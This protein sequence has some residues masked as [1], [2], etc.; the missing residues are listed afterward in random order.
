M[1]HD[2]IDLYTRAKG[3]LDTIDIEAYVT[4]KPTPPTVTKAAE[5]P[6]KKEANGKVEEKTIKKEEQSKEDKSKGTES[7]AKKAPGKARDEKS[8]RKREDEPKER[9]RKKA[10]TRRS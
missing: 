1:K 7:G 6:D 3:K 4:G 2:D 9:P 5:A 10:R 8:S